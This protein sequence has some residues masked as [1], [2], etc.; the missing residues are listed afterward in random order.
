MKIANGSTRGQGCIRLAPACA[1]VT[2]FITAFVMSPVGATPESTPQEGLAPSAVTPDAPAGASDRQRAL[3]LDYSLVPVGLR[4]VLPPPSAEEKQSAAEAGSK[5][6]VM[7]GYHRD[8]PSDFKGDLSPQIDWTEQ[9]DGT[10]VSSL[11]VTS[12]GAESVRVG[13][14]AELGPEGEIRFFGAQSDNQFPVVTQ[15]DFQVLGDE[16]QTL[17]SPTVE[18]DTIGIEITLPSEKAMSVFS[19]TIDEVAHTFVSTESLPSAFK[20]DCP[21][22]H[23]DVACRSSSIRENLQ[24]AVA[25]IRFEDNGSYICSGTLLN[26]KVDNSLVPYFLTANHCVDT[27]SVARTVEAWW[28]YQNARCGGSTLDSRSTR[29]T[30]G[31]DLLS[32]NSRYDLS[33]LRIRGGVPGGLVFSGWTVNAINHPAGV[34]GI[35]HPDGAV[36]SY[37]AG[38]SVHNRLSD[39]VVNAIAV[40]W[41]DGTTEGGSSGSGLFLRNG[42]YLVGALS[43]G[44]NCGYRITDKYGPFRDF[45][46][47]ISRWMDPEGSTPITDRD[48]HGDT[49]SRATL[50]RLPSSTA[51]N[52]ERSQD[53]DYFRFQLTTR[54][55]LRVHTTGSTD[56]YGTLTRSGSSFSRQ[57]DDD[58]QGTNF[59][60]SASGALAGTY[61]VEV[62]GY[63]A[64]TTGTYTLHVAGSGALSPADHVLP[65]VP[66][67]SNL[68]T[69]G[70]IRITNRSRRAGSVL[71]HGV[72]DTGRRFGPDSLPLNAEHSKFF[73]SRDLEQGNAGLGLSGIG[74]GGGDWRVEL[75]TD[76]NIEAQAYVRTPDGFLTS[77]HQ[78]AEESAAGSRRYYLPWF[79]P[80]SNVFRVSWLRV[81]NPGT[82]PANIVITGVDDRGNVPPGG[83]VRLTLQGGAARM[84]SAIQLEQGGSGLQGRLGDGEGKW[85][86][87]VS[88]N[89][90]L[91]VM[92]LLRADSG[93][94]SNLSR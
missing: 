17:W 36:K 32:T 18:G 94:L 28:F 19:L 6:R 2:A 16:I 52:L 5:R 70:V 46:P 72:D 79:N 47:Q 90:P 58:G 66:R 43:H 67:A 57:N 63:N 91:Q 88:A 51:G 80:A 42:G 87:Y 23:I 71:I 3:K 12:P 25:H 15:D 4:I 11:S 30:S 53:R 64:A 54:D 48:D 10:F 37:S 76:L 69:A 50:V 14:R 85:R 38:S 89:L 84:L 39:G 60:I 7:V 73:Y 86:L 59:Q 78:I 44:P 92:S 24:N 77:M 68:Q 45:F 62:R 26:D 74:N 33:L 31:T 35:H 75:R 29:T 49:S 83:S 9:S 40:R 41:S 13:I 34:Y 93:H 1:F 22:L 20:L 8:V 61:Y 82:G 81:I 65:L 21:N 27:V 56:T 55:D